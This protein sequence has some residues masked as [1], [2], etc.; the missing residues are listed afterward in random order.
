[1]CVFLQFENGLYDWASHQSYS[2]ILR[3]LHVNM[4]ASVRVDG[5]IRTSSSFNWSQTGVCACW[6]P[7]CL[8]YFNKVLVMHQVLRD[9]NDGVEIKYRLDGNIFLTLY[10]SRKIPPPTSCLYSYFHSYATVTGPYLHNGGQCTDFLNKYL[11]G[12]FICKLSV[13]QKT[14][15]F[16]LSNNWQCIVVLRTQW[17]TRFL[18][19]WP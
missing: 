13:F 17:R 8:T 4:E 14:S 1:M 19:A 5:V 15:P 2:H 10:C 3:G 18:M 9:H 11:W 12:N 7:S 16:G 6:H